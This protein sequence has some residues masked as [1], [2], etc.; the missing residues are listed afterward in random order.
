MKNPEATTHQLAD[1][2]F[3]HSYAKVV[4][5]L[6][7]YFGLDQVEIAE[8][9]VQDTLIEAMEK[10]SSRGIPDNPEGWIMDVAKKKTITA[11]PW[12]PKLGP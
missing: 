5:I 1:H 4:A 3:R 2:F 7:R 6:S 12:L 11:F 8:D 10:W 9:M